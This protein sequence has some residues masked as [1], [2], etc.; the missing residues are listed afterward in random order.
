MMLYSLAAV[1]G[2]GG[3]DT[4]DKRKVISCIRDENLGSQPDKPDIISIKG[5]I[6][7]IKHDN[8][9]WYTACPTPQC[10]KKVT[11]GMNGQWYCEKCG[12][13]YETVGLSRRK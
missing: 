11:E 6:I 7:Y 1:G 4:L 2:G 8:D 5:T 9:P 12:K 10:N 3:V 13:A